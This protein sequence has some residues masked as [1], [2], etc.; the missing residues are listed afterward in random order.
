MIAY[1]LQLALLS[2]RRSPGLTA[3]MV[4]IIGVGV[5]A[6]MTTYAV[7]RAVSGNPLPD[8]S[9]QL[10]VPQIDNLGP[11]NGVTRNHLPESLTYTDAMALMHAHA[12]PAQT[13]I[14]PVADNV[15]PQDGVHR[16]FAANGYAAYADFFSMFEVPFQYGHGW[17]ANDDANHA[18]VI[19]ISRQLNQRLFS[20]GNSVGRTLDLNGHDY[21]IAGV[22]DDWNPQPRFYDLNNGTSFA[23]SPDFYVPFTRA[24][25]LH[26]DTSGYDKCSESSRP[27]VPGWDGWL[28]SECLWV[29]FWVALPDAA[30]VNRYRQFLGDYATAQQRAGRFHWASHVQLSNLTGWLDHEGAVPPETR[31]SM[32]VAFGFLVVCLVN[33]M[34]L[35]LAR[36][37]RRAGEIGVRRALGASRGEIYRQFAVEAVIVGLAGGLL[38]LALTAAGVSSADLLFEPEVAKLAHIDAG[39]IGLTVLLAMTATAVAG[40]YPAWRASGVQPSWQLKS[41]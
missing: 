22:V 16:P 18:N 39:L 27:V 30:A 8:K 1:Y 6:S 14:Y 4:L 38:G 2:F 26:M 41:Q 25:D 7:F 23:D 34:G 19:A 21:R 32:L 28:R 33:M 20:G 24:V 3:L 10:F 11:Q 29:S 9:A 40:I 12:A 5:A 15:V 35:L 31:V 36:I 37:M 13:A 17:R